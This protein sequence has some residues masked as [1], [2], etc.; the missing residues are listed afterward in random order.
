MYRGINGTPSPLLPYLSLSLSL[1]PPP[2][3]ASPPTT[4]SPPPFFLPPRIPPCPSSYH[5]PPP[6][7]P[8]SFCIPLYLCPASGG[9]GERDSL[10]TIPFLTVSPSSLCYVCMCV[11]ARACV[12]MYIYIYVYIFPSFSREG[13]GGGGGSRSPSYDLP[14]ATFVFASAQHTS[15]IGCRGNP[16]SVRWC[17]QRGGGT[18]GMREGESVG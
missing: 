9:R 17:V 1:L 6:P 10:I 14:P 12:Y 4:T 15:Q 5:G 3:T 16:L 8:S 7:Q 11:Y 18:P 2:S 13:G